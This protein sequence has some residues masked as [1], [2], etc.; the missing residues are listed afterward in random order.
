M[1]VPLTKPYL[2]KEEAKRAK[3][4]ILSGWHTQGPRVA[5]MEEEFAQYTGSKYAVA[6][7]SATTGLFLSLRVA[8]IGPGDEVIV[9]SFSFIASANVIVHAGAKPVFVDVDSQTFNVDLE[10]L[11]KKITKKTKAI[12]PVDQVGLPCDLN[13]IK[14]IAKKHKLLVVEDAA[15]AIGSEYR[16]KGIGGFSDLTC[17]SFHP[18]KIISCGEG[19]LITTNKKSYEQALKLWRHQGMSVSDV[20]RHQAKTIIFEK[21]PV[22]GY[23]FRMTDIQAAI[24]L[25]QLKKLPW[26][27]K[28]RRF[29]A[30]RYNRLLGKI[31]CLEVPLEPEY[32]KH[33]WQ[34]YIVKLKDKAPLKQKELM[35]RLLK[36]GIASRRGVMAS[37]LEPVYRKM[38]GKTSLPATEK[39]VKT[40]ICLPLFPEMTIAQHDWIVARLKKHLTS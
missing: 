34:S 32:A 35:L 28:K 36:D 38:L 3:E 21:Y 30:E 22:V 39:L 2:G 29:F 18:R 40:T 5:E 15:C 31:N 25:E 7:S 17:F 8:G 14:G 20:E 1:Q 27:L 19:G 26:I 9:P 33:N 13:G 23:N 37:H 24:L 12:I 16:G 4:V 11:E 6:V 10:D